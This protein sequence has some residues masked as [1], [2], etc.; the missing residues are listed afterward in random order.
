VGNNEG[1]TYNNAT[2]STVNYAIWNENHYWNNTNDF[3]NSGAGNMIVRGTGALYAGS[4]QDTTGDP[5]WVDPANGDFSFPSASPLFD[6]SQFTFTG[7]GVSGTTISYEDRGSVQKE[8]TGGGLHVNM[9]LTGG[10]T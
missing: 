6:A 8:A 2:D 4:P 1:I 9:P 7:T 3:V 5:Q 10:M